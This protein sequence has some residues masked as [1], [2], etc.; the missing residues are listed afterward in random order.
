MIDVRPVSGY[1][2]PA[3]F[4]PAFGFFIN[5][6]PVL[7]NL[8]IFS[9]MP[10]IRGDKPNRTMQMNIVIPENKLIR[11]TARILDCFK[12]RSW[13]ARP[14]FA[15]SKKRF[16]IGVVVADSRPAERS[17]DPQRFKFGIER[18]SLLGR[19]I[20]RMQHKRFE[21]IDTLWLL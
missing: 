6:F 14:I 10:L 13:I 15:R 4:I 20:V 9:P 1:S 3:V 16:R 2:A 11:P 5:Y 21:E 19:T 18:G 8:K 17:H 12:S 7:K